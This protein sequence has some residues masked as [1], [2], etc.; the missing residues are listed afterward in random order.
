M[1]ERLYNICI[2]VLLVLLAIQQYRLAS[3]E[4][5]NSVLQYQCDYLD[6]T[7][8][9]E[10]ATFKQEVEK[11]KTEIAEYAINAELYTC[12]INKKSEEL[13]DKAKAEES[14]IQNELQS[15]S[16]NDNQL[17]ISRRI[18]HDFSSKKN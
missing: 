5:D 10:Q 4:A 17:N 15:D 6:E 18:I 16:S 2:I 13:D 12:T 3:L 1:S 11:L 14:K 8:R 7:L 9:N